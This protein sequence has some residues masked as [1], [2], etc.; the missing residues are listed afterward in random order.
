MSRHAGGWWR[1]A[2]CNWPADLEH[3]RFEGDQRHGGSLGYGAS[4]SANMSPPSAVTRADAVDVGEEGEGRRISKGP[5]QA[6]CAP[7]EGT[8]ERRRWMT[9]RVGGSDAA[10]TRR[11]GGRGGSGG[12]TWRHSLRAT[13]AALSDIGVESRVGWRHGELGL[14][15]WRR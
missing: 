5:R 1:D 15:G 9:A 8:G 4:Q 13:N 6:A 3:R 11:N 7:A 12:R 14:G 10:E 2:Y